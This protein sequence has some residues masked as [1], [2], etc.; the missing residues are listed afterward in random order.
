MVLATV[1]K[2]K[3]RARDAAHTV[4][5]AS[6]HLAVSSSGP[7]RLSLSKEP[8]NGG[9]L[10]RSIPSG[11]S[12]M[13]ADSRGIAH[14]SADTVANNGFSDVEKPHPPAQPKRALHA[15]R[16]CA[17]PRQQPHHPRNHKRALRS[18]AVRCDQK[19]GRSSPTGT[20]PPYRGTTPVASTAAA[21]TSGIAS[22]PIRRKVAAITTGRARG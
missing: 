9:P 14:E 22:I 12:L 5:G 3:L 7:L 15:R 18:R 16:R 17:L 6:G 8:S 4:A 1:S 11:R 20:P 13:S 2:C 19:V 10:A 21:S